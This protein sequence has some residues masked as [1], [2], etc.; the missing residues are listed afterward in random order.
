MLRFDAILIRAGTVQCT[1]P[2]PAWEVL[3]ITLKL[4]KVFSA[5]RCLAYQTAG[6]ELSLLEL[7]KIRFHIELILLSSMEPGDYLMPDLCMTDQHPSEAFLVGDPRR[8]Q[9]TDRP[10][11]ERLVQFIQEAR[12]QA[13]VRRISWH[14]K[15][16]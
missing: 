16:Q 9:F 2:S 10:T 14:P 4:A 5:D 15:L 6:G 11:L 7:Q 8:E 12:G 13:Q 1:L 3:W